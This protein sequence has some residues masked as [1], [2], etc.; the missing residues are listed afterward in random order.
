MNYEIEG[1]VPL[2][3]IWHILDL[4]WVAYKN[5][6]T[7]EQLIDKISEVG[8]TYHCSCGIRWTD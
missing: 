2:K 3:H 8:G 5:S 1:E 6:M 4:S 7:V